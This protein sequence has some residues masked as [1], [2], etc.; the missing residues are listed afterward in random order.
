[1]EPIVKKRVL[2]IT[3]RE[4]DART[5]S[6]YMVQVSSSIRIQNNAPQATNEQGQYVLFYRYRNG[7]FEKNIKKVAEESQPWKNLK[8]KR[9][10][11]ED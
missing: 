5:L 6:E 2:I 1:M 8:R 4:I 7:D 3:S 9:A 11:V 10:N